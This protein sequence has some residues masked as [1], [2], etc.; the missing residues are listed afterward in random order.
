MLYEAI[1]L[2]QDIAA[3]GSSMLSLSLRLLKV[4]IFFNDGLSN[5][6]SFQA[7]LGT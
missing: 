6:L 5:P 7:G 1:G 4:T 2:G 3:K